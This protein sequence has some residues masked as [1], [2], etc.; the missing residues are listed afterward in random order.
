MLQDGRR[1][2]R[3]RVA[4]AQPVHHLQFRQFTESALAFAL[5]L[6]ALP[7]AQLQQRLDAEEA[8]AAQ[9]LLSAVSATLLRA[10]Q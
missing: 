9:Q 4:A 7:L 6:A 3:S 10:K 8:A 1:S 5:P 2:V